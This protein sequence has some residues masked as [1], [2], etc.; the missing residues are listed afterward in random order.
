MMT[1]SPPPILYSFRRC[2][3]AIRARMALVYSQQTVQLR[4]VVLKNKPI[5]MLQASQ[6]GTVPVLV[7]ADTSAGNKVIDE[8]LEI[9]LWS[10]E[11]YDPKKW[12]P[13]NAKNHA[14][15]LSLIEH[16][17]NT[18]KRHLDHYKYADRFPEQSAEFYRSQ[19]E[20]FLQ[21]LDSKLRL[22][23]YLFGPT[24]TLADIAIFPFIRQF[25]HVD[26]AWFDQTDYPKLQA[27]LD[28]FLQSD[29]FNRIMPKFERWQ[30]K[31]EPILL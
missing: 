5:A 20:G 25:A 27:W 23:Q 28:H 1:P 17:D 13:I 10:L 19:S 18:F 8:S 3:Y 15:Q 4:E 7:L 26:K 11:R 22:N 21:T 12:L 16:N 29:L 24:P 9:M 14:I 30:P 6:K 31:A 2:P